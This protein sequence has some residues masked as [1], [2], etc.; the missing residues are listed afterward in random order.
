MASRRALIFSFVY[1]PRFVGGAEVAVKEIT[2]RISPD[3]VEFHMLALRVDADLLRRERIGN[4]TVHR[5]GWTWLGLGFNKY[6]YPFLAAIKAAGLHRERRFDFAWSIMASYSGFAALFFKLFH[7]DV[8]FVLSLQEGDPV[9][10]IRSKSLTV[11][12][13]PLRIPVRSF[14]YPVLRMIFTHADRVQ[15]ISKHLASFARL[16]GAR[17]EAVVIPNG[18]DVNR[19]SRMVPF[20]EL[21]ELK[22]SLG[23]QPGEAF[24]VTASRLVAKNAVGRIVEALKHLPE[25][26]KL[27][28]LGQGQEEAELRRL[29]RDLGVDGRVVFKGF[30]SHDD[31]PRYLQASDIF[32]RPSVSEG[33]GNSFIEAMA[34]GVPV[35]ATPVGGI[36]DFLRHKET[37]LFC[38][39]NSPE[40][41]AR[42]AEVYLRD[43][44]LRAE[45]VDNALHMVVDHYDWKIVA[46][47]M[48]ERVFKGL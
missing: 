46:K 19:F 28:V 33:F 38:E 4:V 40:D 32:V 48:R 11:K 29:A 6:L 8:P 1:Y 34:A 23:K 3:D 31:L 30:V 27:L 9:D 26:V 24:L 16:M 12:A 18:V 21:E 43:K 44:S 13:G 37:G 39:V 42:K 2:D 7:T 35:I 22:R 45:I 36:V 5:I 14:M 17:T 25:S 10:Y 47:D 20:A 15:A 41:I